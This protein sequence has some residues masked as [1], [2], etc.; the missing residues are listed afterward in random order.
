MHKKYCVFSVIV[1]A[2]DTVKQPVVV[3]DRFDYIL[4][5]DSEVKE[6]GV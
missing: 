3:D 4:F 5:S 1:G 2:Y 6:A